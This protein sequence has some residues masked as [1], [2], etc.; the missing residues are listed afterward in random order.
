MPCFTFILLFFFCL[1][2]KSIE[3]PRYPDI[4]L[5]SYLHTCASTG[6]MYIKEFKNLRNAARISSSM[7]LSSMY[8]F[9]S[10]ISIGERSGRSNICSFVRCSSEMDEELAAKHLARGLVYVHCRRTC[11]WVLR[12][13]RSRPWMSALSARG[14]GPGIHGGGCARHVSA[15]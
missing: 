10:S 14:E 1:C 8:S 6:Y 11:I 5:C 4:N 3:V 12:G 15:Y 7:A 9:G 2:G 13:P